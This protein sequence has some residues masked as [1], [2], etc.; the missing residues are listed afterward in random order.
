MKT[1][2]ELISEAMTLLAKRKRP[3]LAKQK[4]PKDWAA[5]IGRIGAARRWGKSKRTK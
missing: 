3:P 1:E 4:R 5:R 2:K